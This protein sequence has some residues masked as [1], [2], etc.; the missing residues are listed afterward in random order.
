MRLALLPLTFSFV[1]LGCHA[2][3]PAPSPFLPLMSSIEQRLD[4]ASSV[5][6]HKW[7]HNLPVTAP[8]REQEVLSRVSEMAP[9]YGLTPERA[10]AFFNDQIE[11]NKLVQYSLIDR[12]NSLGQRPPAARLDLAN[13]IRPRLDEL[14][15]ALLLELSR[16][17]QL[18]LGN[19]PRELAHALATRTNDPLRHQA[20]IR[21]TAHLCAK[22]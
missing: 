12:W 4:L 9:D 13:E 7:D 1:L 6:V 2:H 15:T 19:C 18:Q 14:Q 22:R 17:D 16:L 11:A 21:A 5:A 3:P 20:L 8:A 10:A